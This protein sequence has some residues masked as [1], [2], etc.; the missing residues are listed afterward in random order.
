MSGLI[1][2]LMIAAALL[3]AVCCGAFAW[4]MTKAMEIFED[5]TGF[6]QTLRAMR[7]S[8]ERLHDDIR[9]MGDRIHKL[10]IEAAFQDDYEALNQ[11]VLEWKLEIKTRQE[12]LVE[13]V[14]ALD[15]A[16]TAS[17]TAMQ[18]ADSRAA[19]EV[20]RLSGLIEGVQ[21]GL[22][23]LRQHAEAAFTAPSARLDQVEET[24]DAL[25]LETAVKEPSADATHAL[26][27]ALSDRISALEATAQGVAAWAGTASDRAQG[28]QP[29]DT[30]TADG[31]QS[32][33][34]LPDDVLAM[35]QV[36]VMVDSSEGAAGEAT[37]PGDPARL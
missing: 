19:V 31:S 20:D 4:Q 37:P 12:A 27:E 3:T 33:P 10:G 16:V 32:V 1:D 9:E 36:V 30:P 5:A 2:L 6:D 22:E 7:K 24:V 13:Q 29:A 25:L 15:G 28:A 17:K 35:P 8:I 34:N 23:G 26:I 21:E 18:E 14:G 11:Q